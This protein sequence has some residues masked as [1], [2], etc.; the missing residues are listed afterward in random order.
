MSPKQLLAYF[1]RIAEAPPAAEQNR[2][3]ARV[4]ELT[5]LCDRLEAAQA[6]RERRRDRVAASSLFAEIQPARIQF[7]ERRYQSRRRLSF[8]AGQASHFQEE[9]G[10]GQQRTFRIVDPHEPFVAS[11]IWTD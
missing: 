10:V 4:N 2:I 8:T 1:D 5:A 9:L 3:V 7:A 6:E 11:S